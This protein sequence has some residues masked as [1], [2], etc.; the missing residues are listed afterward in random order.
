[1][2]LKVV[3][4][5]ET[6]AELSIA[7]S[8]EEL[9]K[10]KAKVLKDLAPNV[11]VAGFRT[12][13]VPPE[14]VEKN[15]NYNR[16][17][18]E[19]LDYSMTSLYAAAAKS[20]NLKPVASPKVS[21]KKFVPFT[22]LEFDLEVACVGEIKLPNYKKIKVPKA[23]AKVLAKD[24]D[25]VIK[26]L[27]TRAAEKVDVDRSAK[28][29]DQVIIDFNGRDPKGEPVS[30]AS[31]KDYPLAL[32]SNAFIPGFEPELVGLKAGDSKEF[33]ITFPKDYGSATLQ[34]KKVTFSVTVNKVQELNEPVVDDAFAASI[35]PFKKL[36]ELKADIKKQLLAE[37]Q[38]VAT[39]AHQEAVV[40]A[41]ADKSTAAIPDALVEEQLDRMEEEEKQNLI[42]RGQTWE[43]H[44]EAEGVTPEK[45]REQ[46]RSGAAE[47]V[48]VGLV[49]SEIAAQEKLSIST[50]ELDA[51]MKQL[52]KQYSDPKMQ[53]ELEKLESR[54]EIASRMLSEKAV[55][56]LTD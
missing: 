44:L 24:I 28:M 4:K 30:G 35:G 18:T 31:G 12:G 22:E 15:V 53:A 34:N 26:N 47:R 20:E 8:V 2:R 48:K 14:V 38:E 10:F 9:N 40:K 37:R 7:A 27:Q 32:G 45:H 50:E 33:T 16:L 21:V 36:D 17:Q 43:Q 5:N 19:F 29:N 39:R 23:E 51:R 46:K 52:K 56:V 1:M 11:K 6:T 13:H 54:R 49:L 55:R 3:W 25:E 41:V 42:Y